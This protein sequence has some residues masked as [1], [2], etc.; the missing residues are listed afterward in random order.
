MKNRQLVTAIEVLSPTNKRGEGR[1]EYLARRRR[2]FLSTA[3]LMEI[4]LLRGGKRVPMQKA[5]PPAPYFVFLSRP[6]AGR[7]PGSG[8]SLWIR[9][10]PW[11][12][13]RSCP[14]TPTS[15]STSNWP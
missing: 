9:P 6:R 7:S 8:R 11:S 10:C 12:Q 1:G 5:L 4:D 14:A 3:H 13:S 2:L 15:R